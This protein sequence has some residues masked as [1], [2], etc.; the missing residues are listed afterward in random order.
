MYKAGTVFLCAVVM[1]IFCVVSAGSGQADEQ[2]CIPMGS[3]ELAAPD[4]VDSQRSSVDF[5]HSVHFSYACQTCHHTWN[6]QEGIQNC[7]TSG[8]HSEIAIPKDPET[9][10]TIISQRIKYYKKAYHQM[11]IGC[12]KEISEKNKEIELAKKTLETPLMKTG[13]TGCIKCHPKDE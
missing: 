7:T 4:G 13:P 2:L 12:H 3:I 10:K 6:G 8:C 9:G 11:C 5:P 1:A